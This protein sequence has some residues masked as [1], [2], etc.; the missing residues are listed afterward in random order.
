MEVRIGNPQDRP[1]A[2][3][4]AWREKDGTGSK[5]IQQ[6]AVLPYVILTTL[7]IFLGV[8]LLA[9][10][11]S[12]SNLS[13]ARQSDY[14]TA[15]ESAEY[16]MSQTI[17]AMNSAAMGYL[18]VTKFGNWA[19]ITSGELAPCM[20][21]TS[22]F[23][24]GST[25][26]GKK[27]LPGL[28]SA[29]YEVTGFTEPQVYVT[30]STCNKFGNLIGGSATIIVTGR[31][32]RTS[33]SAAATYQL[34][35]RIHVI[36]P[37][38]G[39]LGEYPLIILGQNSDIGNADDGFIQ[40]DSPY[41]IDTKLDLGIACLQSTSCF[42]SGKAAPTKTSVSNISSLPMPAYPAP[43]TWSGDLTTLRSITTNGIND[44]FRNFPYQENAPNTLDT[45]YC[46]TTTNQV[47]SNGQTEITCR[48][49][50]LSIIQESNGKAGIF[51]ITT[52]PYPVNIYLE[53]NITAE[54][55]SYLGAKE[56]IDDQDPTAWSD[57]R[58]FGKN[59]GSISAC[60]TQTLTA[61]DVGLLRGAFAWIPY[62]TANYT[63]GGGGGNLASNFG[64][65]WT[66]KFLGPTSSNSFYGARLDSPD[67][68][69]DIFGPAFSGI[70]DQSAVTGIP[71][72]PHYYRGYGTSE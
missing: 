10:R 19:T 51:K 15:K 48:V 38:V 28:S 46:T 7:M 23:Q 8:V 59:Q 41:S 18:W 11:N 47:Y 42:A 21:K 39:G 3:K 24:S 54:A 33:G 72:S 4:R 56:V 1:A 25:L 53:G 60:N 44:E 68:L 45:R 30:R 70:S 34:S 27:S 50:N 55:K 5:A 66:C 29:S 52:S 31:V 35:R 32:E 6:G 43:P 71:A 61:A 26:L 12:E 57:L 17:S 36:G 69:G 65:L 37:T 9:T 2:R 13:S 58:I 16:G 49:N 64:I 63:A 14:N 40:A 22:S 20:I 67:G 62:G